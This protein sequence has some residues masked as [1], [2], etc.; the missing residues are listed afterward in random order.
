MN[1]T[2]PIATVEVGHVKSSTVKDNKSLLEDNHG[3][4][5]AMLLQIATK[6]GVM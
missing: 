5:A 4:L 2:A 3:T 6:R 1:A